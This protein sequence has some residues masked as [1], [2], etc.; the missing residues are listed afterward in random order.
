A[1]AYSV[2]FDKDGSRL[3]SASADKTA[4]IWDVASGRP[5]QGLRGHED[6]VRCA[7]FSPDGGTGVTGSWDGNIRAWGAGN[8]GCCRSCHGMKGW[9]T[10]VAFS[11]AN[12]WVADGGSA[13]RT[14]VWDVYSGQV[15]RRFESGFPSRP[16]ATLGVAFSP[17]GWRVAASSNGPDGV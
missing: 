16:G 9:I 2:A 13:G 3:V 6:N 4:I 12:L 14:E 1:R 7:V 17:D 11:P 8:G 5:L 10:R 15:V